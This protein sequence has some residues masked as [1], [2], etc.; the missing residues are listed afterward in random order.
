V[1]DGKPQAEER[2]GEERDYERSECDEAAA[3][4]AGWHEGRNGESAVERGGES[5]P[6]GRQKNL[7]VVG[8]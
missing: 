4:R 7:L 6:R 3:R 8:V 5:D 1:T 2:P